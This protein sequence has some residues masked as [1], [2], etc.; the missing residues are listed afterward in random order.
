MLCIQ[1]EGLHS[2]PQREAE[3]VHYRG[4]RNP[5]TAWGKR[6]HIPLFIDHCH[7]DGAWA[8]IPCRKDVCPFEQRGAGP[9]IARPLVER[10]LSVVNQLTPTGRVVFGEEPL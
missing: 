5:G 8:P 9:R 7:I 10:R 6:G 3:S 2:G 4:G 1:E